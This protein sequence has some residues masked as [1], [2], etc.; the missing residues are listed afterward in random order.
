MQNI[1]NKVTR[2]RRIVF[3]LLVLIIYSSCSDLNNE[4]TI[5]NPKKAIDDNIADINHQMS[6]DERVFVSR[7]DSVGN[8]MEG[9][10]IN[11]KKHGVWKFYSVKNILDS[12]NFYRGDTVYLKLDKDDYNCEFISIKNKYKVSVPKKWKIENSENENVLLSLFKNC[13]DSFKPVITITYEKNN[14]KSFKE[15]IENSIY[16]L[17]NK[18]YFKELLQS[19]LTKINKNQAA[20]VS[21]EII[22]N[23][24][25]AGVLAIFIDIN[26]EIFVFTGTAFNEPKGEFLRYKVVFEKIAESFSPLED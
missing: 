6:S 8:R 11:S 17:Q 1:I 12:V 9:D 16:S 21:F 13:N 25:I 26:N 15:Y 2:K 20:Y 7:E 18:P 4:K 22:V 24:E 5:E 14:F 10:L 23:E 3:L 19:N